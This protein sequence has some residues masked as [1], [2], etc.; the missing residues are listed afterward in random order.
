MSDEVKYID[1]ESYYA[2]SDDKIT[3][4]TIVLEY[5][6]KI[7]Q[8]CTVEFRGGY[9]SIATFKEGGEKEIYVPDTREILCNAIFFFHTLLYPH[10]K[11]DTIKVSDKFDSDYDK[12]R[13][14]FMEKT[15][16]D[17]EVI[18]GEAYYGNKE[19]K[20]QLEQYKQK[21]VVLFLK[22]FRDI[23][24]FLKDNDYMASKSFEEDV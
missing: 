16:M 23:N 8:L 7:G 3:F 4:R 24:A 18:L 17:E 20:L 11:K 2:S 12:L 1:A 15:D 9:Y 10:Y 5:L 19:E 13:Q 22:L 6:R 21:K 14:E